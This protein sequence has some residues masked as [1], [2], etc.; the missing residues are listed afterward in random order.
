MPTLRQKKVL[1]VLATTYQNLS[2]ALTYTN[3]FELLV[4]VILSAQCTDVRVNIITKRLFPKY[5]S[6]DIWLKELSLVKLM[7]LIH[8]CGLF[9]SKAK[10]LLAT[11]QL[12]VDKHNCQVPPNFEELVELPGVGR[13]TANVMLSQAF[14]VP[15]IAVDTHVFRTSRRLGLA[16]ADTVLAVE[17]ELQETIPRKSWSAAHHWLIWH[18]RKVCKA[19]NPLCQQCPL[20]ELCASPDKKIS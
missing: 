2:T 4:A 5:P 9:R 8:D 20:Q 19:R 11:C 6:P 15:A 12:L 1:Q 10:N 7:E 16:Q 14:G 3:N 17:Q 13:K 18:G